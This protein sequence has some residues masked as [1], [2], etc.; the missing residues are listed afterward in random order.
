MILPAV[1]RHETRTGEKPME[2]ITLSHSDSSWLG[3]VVRTERIYDAGFA[4]TLAAAG[5]TACSCIQREVH[6]LGR[7][8][9]SLF[10]YES[11]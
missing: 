10:L 7:G 9:G 11:S 6:L 2:L 4:G 3:D 1:G 5:V 8:C